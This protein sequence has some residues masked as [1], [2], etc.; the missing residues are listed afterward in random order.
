VRGITGKEEE[1]KYHNTSIKIAVIN[2]TKKKN[3]RN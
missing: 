2:E 3:T 1:L